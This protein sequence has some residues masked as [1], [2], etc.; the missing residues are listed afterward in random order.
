MSSTIT[1]VRILRVAPDAT[2][3]AH[4]SLSRASASTSDPAT[5]IADAWRTALA[6][7]AWLAGARQLKRDGRDVVWLATLLGQAVVV[8]AQALG[9]SASLKALVGRARLQRQWLG[10]AWLIDHH[11]PTAR[12]LALAHARLDHAPVHLLVTSF[13]HGPSLLAFM[14]AS[15]H[16][17]RPTTPDAHPAPGPSAAQERAVAD[18]VGNLVADLLAR[19][20]ANRDHKPSN[21]IVTRADDDGA[22][23]ALIDAVALRAFAPS[24]RFNASVRML[25]SLLI[26]PTGCGVAPRLALRRRALRAFLVRLWLDQAAATSDASTAAPRDPDPID[27]EWE[28]QSARA[29]WAAVGA[30]IAAHGDPQ[31][32]INPLA[33]P[34]PSA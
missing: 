2:P 14:Q 5:A 19:G 31:P 32:R 4:A 13:L 6:S 7:P 30:R 23:V 11:L 34:A 8:K 27:P 29:F 20:R 24:D 21:L 33:P 26:E 1:D 28:R 17:A 10:H 9:L 16:S 22:Q 18:A 15:R 25:A 3:P 12:P